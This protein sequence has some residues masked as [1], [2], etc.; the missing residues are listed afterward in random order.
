MSVSGVLDDT[1]TR[2]RHLAYGVQ[3]DCDFELPLA[4]DGGSGAAAHRVRVASR[5]PA[6]AET[7]WSGAAGP[8]LHE[9]VLADGRAFSI[10]RGHAGDHLLRYGPHRFFLADGLDRIA[11]TPPPH[12]DPGWQRALLDWVAY[13]V[14]VLAGGHCLH[15]AAVRGEAGV[16]AV[17]APSSGGKTTLA[18]ALR[19]G[20]AS[21]FCDDAL[22]LE[23][24]EGTVI[25]HPGPPYASV[26]RLGEELWV[27]VPGAARRPA[28]LAAAV[29]LDRT[30]DGPR[31]PEIRPAGPLELRGLM[32]GFPR[33][34]HRE[35]ALFALLAALAGQA[36]VLRLRAAR[37][38]PASLLA[39]SLRE[40]LGELS[41]SGSG[42]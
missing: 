30:E 34:E 13:S 21:F 32:A 7:G 22:F 19:A 3:L 38:L 10:E 42:R 20:G 17:A 28:P 11:C 27:G 23:V 2:S 35:E 14:A 24:R 40:R 8:P 41:G 12:P 9:T 26:E 18:S 36:P 25:A 16:L 5:P 4:S 33:P 29:I 31:V 37:S 6:R 39:D 1:T 15:A